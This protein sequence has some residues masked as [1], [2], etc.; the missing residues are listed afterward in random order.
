MSTGGGSG[1]RRRVGVFFGGQSPEFEVSCASAASVVRHLD[2]DRYD[3][4]AVGI[5]PRGTWHVLSEED[6]A[7]VRD[8]RP[9]GPA[10]RD[11]LPVRG[12]VVGTEVLRGL[13]VAF[14]VLHGGV[15]ENGSLQGLFEVFGLPYVGAGVLASATAMDKAAT[16]RAL[17]A[18]GLDVMPYLT[19]DE[20]TEQSQ[21]VELAVSR[22]LRPPWFVKPAGLGSSIGITRVTDPADLGRAIDEALCHDSV[23]LVEE[24]LDGARELECGVLGG[25]AAEASVVGEVT[26][27]GGW[28]DYRQ[29]YLATDDPMT[30][31]ARLPVTVSDRVRAAS[32]RAFEAI[33]GWGLARVD[34]LY[35]ERSDRLV[36]NE[37]NTIPGFTAHSM[38]PKVWAA[39]GVPYAELL[40]RLVLLA[41]ERRH[42]TVDRAARLT[43]RQPRKATR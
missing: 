33:G 3:V 25:Y 9:D 37:L 4:V 7:A 19:V 13:M 2:P 8:A 32:L 28:F 26:V 36:V 18:A 31:P 16:K 21:R 27:H 20:S 5:G 24:G 29:K 41:L 22:G 40:D 12:P 39:L 6:V 35:D 11:R 10:I 17:L 43:A 23:A 14:P 30:V 38:Y 34:F 15:G 1:R 42:R